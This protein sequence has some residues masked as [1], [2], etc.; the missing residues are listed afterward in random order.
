LGIAASDS[1]SGL[2]TEASL[3]K[4]ADKLYRTME[5]LDCKH[6]APGLIFLRHTTDG[7]ELKRPA[8][9]TEYP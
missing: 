7:V 3:F 8:L 4:A 5:P 6:V 1:F 2:G 9:L